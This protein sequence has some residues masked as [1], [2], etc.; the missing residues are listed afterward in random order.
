[1]L[2]SIGGSAFNLCALVA[3][4][5]LLI[6]GADVFVQE[7]SNIAR[8][9]KIPELVIG[10]TI[11]AF[12]TSAPELAIGITSSFHQQGGVALGDVVGSNIANIGLVL[13][14]SAFI[15]PIFIKEDVLKKEF[16]FLI[17]ASFLLIL[18]SCDHLIT[19]TNNAITFFEA[20]V[21]LLCVVYYCVKSIKKAKENI[22]EVSEEK[23]NFSLK[24]IFFLL[25][26]LIGI[27]IGAHFVT[28]S[29]ASF[30][31]SIG[32]ALGVEKELLSNLI[33]LTIIAVGT[34]LPE[35]VTSIIAAK[36]GQNEIALGNV[37]GSNIFNILFICGVSGIIRPLTVTNDILTDIFISF[38][39]TLF[40]FLIGLKKK[41]GKKTGLIL[42]IFYVA[43][44]VYTIIR[45]FN[46]G[47]VITI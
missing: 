47:L 20:L 14:L 35:L 12:G 17:F 10:L 24:S 27:V 30:A 26:G 28:N 36:K 23:N 9:F 15:S 1:M 21:F 38:F 8:K 31:E 42:L 19:K 39:L 33:S 6:K 11:V 45:I 3:G 29:T 32:V 16:P 25:F 41:L 18:F 40:V 5:I 4:I 34:S 22:T 37:I 7:A 44:L 46:P 13:G 43:Y 2:L